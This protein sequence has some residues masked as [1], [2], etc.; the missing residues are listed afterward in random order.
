V[1]IDGITEHV[2]Y[3]NTAYC[4]G[5]PSLTTVEPATVDPRLAVTCFQCNSMHGNCDHPS[6]CVGAACSNATG[7]MGGENVGQIDSL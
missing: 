7:K 3:C 1:L 4:N 5:P 2:C 6:T